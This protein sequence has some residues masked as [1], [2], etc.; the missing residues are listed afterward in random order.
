MSLKH[1]SEKED[2]PKPQDSSQA[3]IQTPT[4]HQDLVLLLEGRQSLVLPSRYWTYPTETPSRGTVSILSPARGRTLSA[5]SFPVSRIF[6]QETALL[7]NCK[8]CRLP[9]KTH[10]WAVA[11]ILQCPLPTSLFKFPLSHLTVPCDKEKFLLF[12]FSSLSAHPIT[13]ERERQ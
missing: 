10:N 4:R 2:C 6:L 8:A 5:L 12:V 3:Q 7:W 9:S 11:V 13:R 1:F